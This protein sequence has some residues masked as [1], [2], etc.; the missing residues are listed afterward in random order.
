MPEALVEVVPL[1]EEPEDEHEL[2][3]MAKHL[4][5]RIKDLQG[6]RDQLPEQY[7]QAKVQFERRIEALLANAGVLHQVRLLETQRDSARV[8]F[9]TQADRR[10]AQ[11]EEL[12][13]LVQHVD[14]RWAALTGSN[15]LS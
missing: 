2:Q 4:R 12:Q 10:T 7:A 11:I 1:E 15:E 6:E 8:S 3:G 14:E 5:A 13:R 9:Q